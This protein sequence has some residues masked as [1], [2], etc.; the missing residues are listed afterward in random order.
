MIYDVLIPYFL[1]ATNINPHI[2][3]PPGWATMAVTL[4][5]FG[6]VQLMSIGILG[7]YIGRIFDQTKARP[8]FIVKEHNVPQ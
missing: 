8:N 7:E 5:F 4:F 6:S 2:T 3:I 1:K